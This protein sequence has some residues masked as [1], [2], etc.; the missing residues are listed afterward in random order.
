MLM[1]TGPAGADYWLGG[2]S[3]KSKSHFGLLISVQDILDLTTDEL[4]EH[5]LSWVK[6]GFRFTNPPRLERVQNLHKS[7]HCFRYCVCLLSPSERIGKN[8]GLAG[9]KVEL[10]RGL[11]YLQLTKIKHTNTKTQTQ[12]TQILLCKYKYTDEH[13]HKQK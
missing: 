4:L 1:Y 8:Q 6:L 3:T 2:S 11:I 9:G 12:I 5:R 13:L 10:W 7:I